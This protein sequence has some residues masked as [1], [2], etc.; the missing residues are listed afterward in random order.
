[1]KI[2]ITFKSPDGVYEAFK[3]HFPES[4]QCEEDSNEEE[5]AR[6][7]IDKYVRYSEYITV[8]FDTVAKTATVLEV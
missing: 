6:D 2:R 4:N 5:Q 7:F 1:M 3:E 8:E